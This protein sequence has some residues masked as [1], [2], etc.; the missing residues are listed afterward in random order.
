M[1]KLTSIIS[2]AAN[3]FN[4]IYMEVVSKLS[5]ILIL[6]KVRLFAGYPMILLYYSWTDEDK[7]I[8]LTWTA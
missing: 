3:P 7:D 4:C 2:F 6:A 1:I 8:E 5:F